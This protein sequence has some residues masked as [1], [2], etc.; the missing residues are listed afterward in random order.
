M[1]ESSAAVKWS[2]LSLSAMVVRKRRSGHLAV[3]VS[4]L[5]SQ[6]N[7]SNCYKVIQTGTFLEAVKC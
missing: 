3:A 4:L 6:N 1:L 7:V 5:H 2:V